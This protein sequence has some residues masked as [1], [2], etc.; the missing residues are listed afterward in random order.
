MTLID[1]ARLFYFFVEFGNIFWLEKQ[2]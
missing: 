2:V 1:L